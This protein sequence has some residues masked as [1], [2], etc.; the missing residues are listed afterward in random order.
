MRAPDKE[1]LPQEALAYLK[2]LDDTVKVRTCT[3]ERKR[4]RAALKAFYN[5]KRETI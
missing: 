3:T 5:Y 1:P 2:T 4:A